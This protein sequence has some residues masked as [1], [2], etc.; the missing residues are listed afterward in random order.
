[1]HETR[2]G[3][4]PVD[5]K[6]ILSKS[7]ILYLVTLIMNRLLKAC[8]CMFSSNRSAGVRQFRVLPALLKIQEHDSEMLINYDFIR[9]KLYRDTS[10]RDTN[11]DGFISMM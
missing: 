2:L 3:L 1:M 5:S 9:K 11:K 4:L 7:I 10:V 6:L 8:S